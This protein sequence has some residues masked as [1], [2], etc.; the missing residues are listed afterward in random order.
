[1]STLARTRIDA[2]L[3]P[4]GS[5]RYLALAVRGGVPE[6]WVVDREPRSARA[7]AY[8][9]DWLGVSLEECPDN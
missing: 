3:F 1:M 4:V 7:S 2:V 8:T 5:D 6:V 9:A